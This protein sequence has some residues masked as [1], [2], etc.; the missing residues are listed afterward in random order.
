MLS[1]VFQI[2][3]YA[4]LC[5]PDQDIGAPVDDTRRQGMFTPPTHLI[6]N[7]VCPGT[8]VCPTFNFLLLLRVILTF[9]C[10]GF[11]A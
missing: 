8:R 5:L 4:I 2:N 10:I 6:P 9:S 11:Y 1:I 3:C 7:L